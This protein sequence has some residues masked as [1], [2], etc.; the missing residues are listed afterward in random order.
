MSENGGTRTFVA[1]FPPAGVAQAI[2]AALAPLRAAPGAGAGVRWV[3]SANLHYTVR[4]LGSL[5]PARVEAARRAVV[6]AAAA[7]APF[8]VRLGASGAFPGPRRP[9]VLWLGAADGAAP[10]ALLAG[11]VERALGRQGFAPAERPFTPHLTVA[12]VAGEGA[13]PAAAA[14]FLEAPPAVPDASFDVREL[15][16]VASTLAPGGSRYEV[17]ER[18]PLGGAA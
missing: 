1:V 11:G 9:R 17:L 15:L 6:A 7:A 13:V 18:A 8:A 16:L 3:R 5:A 12:R 10:L 14:A 4:F 2:D